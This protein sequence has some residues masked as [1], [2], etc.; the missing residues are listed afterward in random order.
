MLDLHDDP[1]ALSAWVASCA[2]EVELPPNWQGFFDRTG[3]MSTLA[4]EN[5]RFPRFYVR[6]LG[7]LESCQSLPGKPR[8]G[9]WHGVYTKDISREGVGFLHSE[10]LYPRERMRIV[11]T[12]GVPR[13]MEVIHCRR[14]QRRCYE[15]GSRFVAEFRHSW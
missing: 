15:I 9:G 2:C 8:D 11:L 7:A 5:R 10:Q 13:L 4:D 14:I 1:K 6:G 12:D 3:V